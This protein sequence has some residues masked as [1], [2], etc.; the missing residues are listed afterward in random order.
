MRG[1]RQYYQSVVH[2]VRD[3]ELVFLSSCLWGTLVPS[4]CVERD[5]K[6]CSILEVK[7]HLKAPFVVKLAGI[8]HGWAFTAPLCRHSVF[9][10]GEQGSSKPSVLPQL[11]TATQQ[12]LCIPAQNMRSL[13]KAVR[14]LLKKTRKCFYANT[15]M[16]YLEWEQ[17]LK[18]TL[19]CR[20]QLSWSA[21]L[22]SRLRHSPFNNPSFISGHKT[23]EGERK[24]SLVSPAGAVISYIAETESLAFSCVFS[25]AV[26]PHGRAVFPGGMLIYR[27]S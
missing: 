14:L 10:K 3:Y 26:T 4:A 1:E 9:V 17:G 15:V 7:G 11:F 8:P 19:L 23:L 20:P 24:F 18:E 13:N 16:H 25:E 5:V 2:T 12:C 21:L 22:G 27:H 6:I